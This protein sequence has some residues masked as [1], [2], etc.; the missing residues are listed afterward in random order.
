MAH[1]NALLIFAQSPKIDRG[2]FDGTFATLPWEELD[3][4]FTATIGDFIKNACGMVNIDILLYRNSQELSDDFFLPFHQRIQLYEL[5]T[6][7]LADQI[8]IAI[9]NAF[10]QGYQNVV[11]VLDNNPLVSRAS[12]RRVYTQLGYEDD[13]I[14]VGPTFEGK[15]Y[16][17]GMKMNHGKIFETTDGDPLS[18]SMV[19]MKHICSLDTMLFLLNPMNSIDTTDNLML[20]M[21]DVEAF[22]KTNV[23]F[24]SKSHAVFKMLE[25]KYRLKKIPE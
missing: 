24:P 14:V 17:V 11:I 7:P 23:E 9:D 10:H 12:L 13:C 21:R 2:K 15:C 22:D 3:A 19:L 8:Q 20:L 25:K 16:I 5:T 1:H 6:A 18:K 4:L